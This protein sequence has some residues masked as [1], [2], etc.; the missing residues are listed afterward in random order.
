[1]YGIPSKIKLSGTFTIC[2]FF[3]CE[4]PVSALTPFFYWAVLFF[5]PNGPILPPL[6]TPLAINSPLPTDVKLLHHILVT[7]LFWLYYIHHVNY[8]NLPI[9]ALKEQ[10]S[11]S[12][13]PISILLLFFRMLL[14][15][16]KGQLFQV[17]LRINRSG[18]LLKSPSCLCLC[19]RVEHV[20]REPSPLGAKPSCPKSRP[21]PPSSPLPKVPPALSMHA[22]D[23]RFSFPISIIFS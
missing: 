23:P 5:L 12:P 6:P 18:S 15:I 3:S 14:V 21:R 8:Y 16:F 4:P 17:G 2:T 9:Q 7:E 19:S 13:C 22:W 11:I 20:D 1:M 10:V